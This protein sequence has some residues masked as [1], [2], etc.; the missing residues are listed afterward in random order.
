MGLLDVTRAG[1]SLADREEAKACLSPEVA[2]ARV[3]EHA[4]AGDA[5]IPALFA[6]LRPGGHFNFP[7]LWPGQI[8]PPDRGG[9]DN[10]YAVAMRLARRSAASFSRQLLPSNLSRWPRCMMR[11]RSGAVTTTSP[12]SLPQS[13]T[14]RFDV[15]MTDDFS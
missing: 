3:L 12:R 15:M 4:G 9:T 6:E 5:E 1:T 2:A 14:L 13:S 7:H 11:S 8:P 10:D